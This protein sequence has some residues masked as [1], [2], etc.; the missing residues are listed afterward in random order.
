MGTPRRWRVGGQDQR[1]MVSD[2]IPINGATNRTGRMDRTRKNEVEEGPATSEMEHRLNKSKKK[3][4]RRQKKEKGKERRGEREKERKTR[5]YVTSK[6]RQTKA[7]RKKQKKD[8][9]NRRKRGR[10]GEAK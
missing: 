2:R 9:S 10:Q 1:N 8:I 7:D 5:H 6:K 3:E 4:E